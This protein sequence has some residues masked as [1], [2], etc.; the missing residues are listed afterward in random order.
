MKDWVEKVFFQSIFTMI[1]GPYI[2]DME[3]SKHQFL[4]TII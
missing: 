4:S 2:C 3:V 1:N